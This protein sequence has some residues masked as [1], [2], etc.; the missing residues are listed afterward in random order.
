V[1]DCA[2]EQKVLYAEGLYRAIVRAANLKKPIYIT[3]NGTAARDMALRSE[4]LK[5]HLYVISK[6]LYDG[7]PVKGYFYWTL[8]DC[9]SWNKGYEAQYGIFAVN[10]LTQERTFRLVY[11][12]LVDVIQQTKK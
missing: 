6:S 4:Y 3:E 5:K 7:Y 8:T 12:Y 1:D 2:A 11:Q 10:R 9:F